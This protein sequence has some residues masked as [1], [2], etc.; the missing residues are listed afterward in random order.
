[1]S[2]NKWKHCSRLSAGWV[3]H[4]GAPVGSKQEEKHMNSL[5]EILLQEWNAHTHIQTQIQTQQ[6]CDWLSWTLGCAFI[7][8]EIR[9]E[10]QE[11]ETAERKSA[12]AGGGVGVKICVHTHTHSLTNTHRALGLC[13]WADCRMTVMNVKQQ[14]KISRIKEAVEKSSAEPAHLQQF[15][16]NFSFYC[17]SS[18]VRCFCSVSVCVREQR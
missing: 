16:F 9:D 8:S 12:A 4:S 6:E 13:V 17:D 14:K 18:T 2:P 10:R 15:L 11:E 7:H 5:R 3:S 1:M